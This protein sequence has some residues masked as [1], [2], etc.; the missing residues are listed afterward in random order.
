MARTAG[1]GLTGFGVN[2]RLSNGRYLLTDK[3]VSAFTND[4]ERAVKLD[5][6]VPFLLESKLV[7]RGAR[8]EGAPE[9]AEKGGRLGAARAAGVAEA[10]VQV[11]ESR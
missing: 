4:E 3:T 9:L 11:L 5:Q 2:V 6:T 8:F 1:V 7:E 10:M